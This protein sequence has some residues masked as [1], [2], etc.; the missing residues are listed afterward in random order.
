MRADS[1]ELCLSVTN[2][3]VNRPL[4]PTSRRLHDAI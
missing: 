3:V 4:D 1:V 2:I